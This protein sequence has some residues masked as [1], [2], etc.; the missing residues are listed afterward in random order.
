MVRGP[1]FGYFANSAKSWII[2]KHNFLEKAKSS[3]D[4]VIIN[5]TS[6]GHRYLESPIGTKE[7]ISDFVQGTI[8]NWSKQWEKLSLI[9][10][11]QPHA[12]Y[13]SFIHG[14]FNKLVFLFRTTLDVSV[15]VQSLEKLF[16]IN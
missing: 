9:A 5:I 15:C 10:C 6:E 13:S 16:V 3:F 1:Q 12:A 2:V 14:F 11:T 4:D 7:F 8:N